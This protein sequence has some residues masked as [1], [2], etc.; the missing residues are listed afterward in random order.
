VPHRPRRPLLPLAIIVV[1][2]LSDYLLWNWSLG[3][4]H[5]IVAL[6]CGMTLIPLLI[7]LLWLLVLAVA[8]LLARTAQRPRARH[9]T[10][11]RHA[12]AGA[13]ANASAADEG[14]GSLSGAK[15]TPTAPP[16]KLAA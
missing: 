15:E 16:S 7:A 11:G 6:V 14:R 1:L 12:A 8:H 3:A 9:P 10:V 2:S 13:G 4:N 5:D